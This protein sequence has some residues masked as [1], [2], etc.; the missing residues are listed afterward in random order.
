M[1]NSPERTQKS[2]DAEAVPAIEMQPDRPQASGEDPEANLE[3][4][5]R[6]ANYT[7]NPGVGVKDGMPPGG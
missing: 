3:T 1:T 4:L 7:T 5:L 2:E 6:L